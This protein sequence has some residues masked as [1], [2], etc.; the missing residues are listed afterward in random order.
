L[1]ATNAG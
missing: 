1:E